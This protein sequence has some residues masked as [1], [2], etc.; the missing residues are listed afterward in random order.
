MK[1]AGYVIR[2]AGSWGLCD[3]KGS[4]LHI[5]IP[6]GLFSSAAEL[7]LQGPRDAGQKNVV[8]LNH[9]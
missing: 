7:T 6:S 8:K 1:T 2:E 4:A 5:H 9:A 3:P